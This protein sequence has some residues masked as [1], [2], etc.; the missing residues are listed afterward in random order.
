MKLRNLLKGSIVVLLFILAGCYGQSDSAK[1]VPEVDGIPCSA[2]EQL[3]FH[4]HTQLKLFKDGREQALPAGAGIKE[5]RCLYWLHTHDTSGIVHIESPTQ[6]DYTLGNFLNIWGNPITDKS[7]A[8]MSI[9]TG[10]LVR[11][12]VNGNLFEGD[13]ST[14][15]LLNNET[16]LL[17]VGPPFAE[18][19]AT[20]APSP[21]AQA[22]P[23]ATAQPTAQPGT[24]TP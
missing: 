18:P 21:T 16:I 23:Q 5:N 3:V 22:S 19:T 24:R 1:P 7:A 8:G 10:Q 14:I 11:A 6:R 9:G 2:S 15:K 17:Q 20:P 4:I 12:Y 13:P